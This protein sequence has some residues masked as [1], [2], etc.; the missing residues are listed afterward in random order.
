MNTFKGPKIY[1]P[2]K[3]FGFR[4]GFSSLLPSL[5]LR[6]DEVPNMTNPNP[7][8]LLATR[9]HVCVIQPKKD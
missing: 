8:S 9:L 3:C 6:S 7:G 1:N 5:R 2:E 4:R